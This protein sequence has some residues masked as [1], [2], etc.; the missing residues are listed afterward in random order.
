[1]GSEHSTHLHGGHGGSLTHPPK[2]PPN[3]RR[4]HTIANPGGAEPPEGGENG[5]PGS[6]S[7]G[8]S[9]CSDTD[10]PYISYTVNRPIG[11][12]PKLTN[13]QI[14]KPKRKIAQ[15]QPK[16][17]AHSIV[18]VKPASVGP[19]VDKDPDIVRLQ[20][21]PMFLPIMRATLNLPAARDP[22]VLE[23][24]DPAPLHKLC[25][26]YQTHLTACANLIA[27]EQNQLTQKVR[28]T[29]G[30]IARIINGLGERQKRFAKY[31]EKLSKV[32]ELSHQLN[33]CHMLLNQ[34]LESMETLNNHLDI[35]DRLEPFVWTTG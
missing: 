6:I 21:I 18:V 4:Q 14:V 11:D 9:V 34:T 30:E 27:T 26:K 35:E 13:K 31:A 20:S 3:I 12:S 5:R 15:K 29:D 17:S 32:Q 8:P 19:N 33:R 22:E 2:Q 24:L 7:P 1:M 25:V 16:K 23:R 28:E 10:L